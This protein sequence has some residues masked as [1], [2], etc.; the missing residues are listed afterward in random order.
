MNQLSCDRMT[1]TIKKTFGRDSSTCIAYWVERARHTGSNG[2]ASI[3]S[4]SDSD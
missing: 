4:P 2:Y 3:D 1:V